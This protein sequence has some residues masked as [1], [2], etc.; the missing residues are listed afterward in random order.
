MMGLIDV[1]ALRVAH[2]ESPSTTP[3]S[4]GQ[5]LHLAS[6]LQGAR[7]ALVGT[8]QSEESSE[9]PGEIAVHGEI[10]ASSRKS[11]AAGQSR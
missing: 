1:E 11:H 4:Q 8:S 3:T 9:N 6:G 10:E 5:T 7:T 2:P